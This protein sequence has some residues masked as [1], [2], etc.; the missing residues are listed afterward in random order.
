MNVVDLWPCLTPDLDKVS[1]TFTSHQRH[2]ANAA[3]DKGVRPDG[4]A[5]KKRADLREWQVM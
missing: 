3:L 1:E 5:V 2:V 4:C